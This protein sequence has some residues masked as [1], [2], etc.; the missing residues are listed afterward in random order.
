MSD[1]VPTRDANTVDVAY[2]GVTEA[3]PITRTST[4]ADV[5]EAAKARFNITRDGWRLLLPDGVELEP[6][7]SIY[8]IAAVLRMGIL[9][10]GVLVLLPRTLP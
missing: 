5:I 6:D 9:D 2:M 1:A 4:T 3:L 8:P 7:D 10:D